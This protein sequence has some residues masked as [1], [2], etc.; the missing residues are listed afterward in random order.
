MASQDTSE[1]DHEQRFDERKGGL[2]AYL[3]RPIDTSLTSIPIILCCFCSGL[4]DSTVFNAWGVFGTMQT[5][6]TVILALGAS[7]QPTGHPHAWLQALSAITFFFLGSFFTNHLGHFLS[8]L[9]R[10]TLILSFFLQTALII[11]AAA[12]IRSGVAPGIIPSGEEH[13]IQLVPLP[14]LAFQA[15][16]QSVTARQLG[17]NEIPTT[18]LTSVYTDLG[19]DPKLFAPLNENWKRNRRALAA[20]ALL[21]GAIIGGWLSRTKEGM[22]AALWFA[23]GVKAVLTVAWALWREEGKIPR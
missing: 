20:V 4:I 19:N 9:K 12:L 10:R 1:S 3:L 5:G 2:G 21:L 16:Q 11:T 15:G 23:A 8:P 18:V 14:M 6:N 22:P 7:S 17:L 13:F